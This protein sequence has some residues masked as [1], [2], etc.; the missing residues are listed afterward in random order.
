M[1]YTLLLN[2]EST[3]HEYTVPLPYLSCLRFLNCGLFWLVRWISSYSLS[4]WSAG[5]YCKMVPWAA[6]SELIIS[7]QIRP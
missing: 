2:L 3:V 6:S 4:E 7:R 1:T 5:G